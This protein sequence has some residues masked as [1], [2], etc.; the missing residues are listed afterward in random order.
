MKWYNK[1]ISP[2]ASYI[3]GC[4][5]LGGLLLWVFVADRA[6]SK[7]INSC[8]IYTVAQITDIYQ[9]RGQTRI[10]YQY[11]INAKTVKADK[12]VTNF[13]TNESWSV[14]TKK[15]SKR[16][17]LLRV[18][19][20]DVSIHQ[21]EWDTYVPDTLRYVPRQGWHTMP[22]STTAQVLVQ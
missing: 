13:D 9:L 7:K 21:I 22:F 16:R 6:V 20:K 1:K 2:K 18:Y 14:D 19:C 5:I 10:G 15:L 3:T 11:K 17:L 4:T 12:G 8:S